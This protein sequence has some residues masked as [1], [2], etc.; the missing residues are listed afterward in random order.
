MYFQGIFFKSGKAL[1]YRNSI[2]FLGRGQIYLLPNIIKIKKKIVRS[3]SGQRL[4]KFSVTPLKDW[5]FFLCDTNILGAQHL[6]G[7]I[8]KWP[9]WDL[10]LK[11]EI[12]A[13][14]KLRL[15]VLPWIIKSFFSDPRI[16]YFLL[17]SMNLWQASLKIG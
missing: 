1:G 5:I 6:P 9:P 17:A 8:S 3:S 7:S 15:P 11:M 12:K 13:I 4:S 16:S 10:G 2:T 14:K